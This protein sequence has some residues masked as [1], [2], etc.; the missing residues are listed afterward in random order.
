MILIEGL[1]ACFLLLITCVVGIANEP[2]SLVCLY[3]KEVQDRVVEKGLITHERINRNANYFRLFGIFPFFI[4][5]LVSV[6]GINGARGFWDGF[7]Q[8]SVILLIEGLFD[9]LFIDWYWVGKTKAWIIPG[10][11]DLMPYIYGKTLIG[12]WVFTLVGYP[13]IAAVLSLIMS[14]ILR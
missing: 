6:Y 12:K 9:R 8:I 10:T 1:V 11:E 3:E 14:L 5:V 2:V 4:F 7:W 13:F